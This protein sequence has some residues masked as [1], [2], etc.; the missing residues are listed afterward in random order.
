M[1][2][3]THYCNSAM[4]ERQNPGWSHP[5]SLMWTG[6]ISRKVLAN[7]A[8]AG[9]SHTESIPIRWIYLK[10][11]SGNNGKQLLNVL[12]RTS[13]DRESCVLFHILPERPLITWP[14]GPSL[15]LLNM[16][17]RLGSIVQVELSGLT[18]PLLPFCNKLVNRTCVITL[19]PNSHCPL[20]LILFQ[21]MLNL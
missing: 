19:S 17:P 20:T 9:C 15:H 3:I 11:Q 18:S 1:T 12:Q 10:G 7:E 4:G 13:G 14:L 2:M 8:G 6:E 21:I 16:V 5:I